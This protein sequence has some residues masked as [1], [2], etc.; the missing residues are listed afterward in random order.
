MKKNKMM[1]L[2]SVMMVLTLMSTSVISGTFAK[3]VTSDSAT[4]VARVAKWGVIVTATDSSVFS[5]T[6]AGTG[7]NT[8]VSSNSDKLV[9]PGTKNEEGVTFSITGTPEVACKVEIEVGGLNGLGELDTA[10]PVADVYLP[11]G[12]YKDMTTGDATDEFTT[13]DGYYP[14]VYK[15]TRT[16]DNSGTPATEEVATGNLA[17]V[18]AAF[19]AKTATYAPNEKLD[20]VCGTYKLTWAWAFE[21]GADEAAKKATDQ[22]DT[23]LGSVA[24][25]KATATGAS[26]DIAFGVKITVTQV[27]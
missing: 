10:L 6:Y 8:V 14:V 3:Y 19:K 12:T 1:R 18:M 22:K 23:L 27:D 9:A 25:G 20:T 4:D 2:A 26:T 11:V 15:L 13:T 17:Q 5:T 16:Y 21:A 7:G 24:D